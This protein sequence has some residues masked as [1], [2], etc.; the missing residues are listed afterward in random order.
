MAIL[1]IYQSFILTG[2]DIGLR[3][4][5]SV[6]EQPNLLKYI[7]SL[8][9]PYRISTISTF[10]SHSS[11]VRSTV[12]RRG[13]MSNDRSW[14]HGGRGVWRGPKSDH[15]ILEQPLIIHCLCWKYLLRIF[16]NFM[17]FLMIQTFRFLHTHKYFSHVISVCISIQNIYVFTSLQSTTQVFISVIK[18]LVPTIL[19]GN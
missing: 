1:K 6:S 16:N 4:Y 9:K 12:G 13:S 18:V 11:I 3:T 2:F 8:T 5:L 10:N 14:S 19:K 7:N 17:S 15:T